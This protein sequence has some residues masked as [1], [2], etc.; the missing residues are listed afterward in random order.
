[1]AEYSEFNNVSVKVEFY[2]LQ[3]LRKNFKFPHFDKNA[4]FYFIKD[5]KLHLP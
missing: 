5:F 1:M 4:R 2:P 3:Y